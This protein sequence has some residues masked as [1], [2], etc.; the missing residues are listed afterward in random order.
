MC[1]GGAHCLIKI[2]CLC[3][4]YMVFG[5]YQV[6]G[7]SSCLRYFRSLVDLYSVLVI[8]DVPEDNLVE[9]EKQ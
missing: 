7:K 5:H 8:T 3:N 9:R 2:Y 6:A 1:L 4:N